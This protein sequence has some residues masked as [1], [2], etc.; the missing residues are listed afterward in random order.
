MEWTAEGVRDM[1]MDNAI[2]FKL[3][4]VM[5][6]M[7]KEMIDEVLEKFTTDPEVALPETVVIV[8]WVVAAIQRGSFVVGHP[9]GWKQP[10]DH[11]SA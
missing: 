6:G 5:E 7:K 10:G 8:D 9:F 4:H 3:G 1:M 2:M 11:P